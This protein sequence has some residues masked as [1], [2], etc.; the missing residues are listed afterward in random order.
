[1]RIAASGRVALLAGWL[2][3]ELP[4][5][6][7]QPGVPVPFQIA[8]VAYAAK[9]SDLAASTTRMRGNA[10]RYRLFT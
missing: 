5:A 7:S 3:W 4:W 10:A 1:M 8:G 6:R 9:T 2:S